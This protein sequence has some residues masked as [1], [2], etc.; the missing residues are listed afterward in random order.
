MDAWMRAGLRGANFGSRQQR[1]RPITPL[2]LALLAATPWG[3]WGHGQLGL[4]ALCPPPYSRHDPMYAC[5]LHGAPTE[6]ANCEIVRRGN[7]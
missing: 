4:A 6:P 1:G 3:G 5:V 7:L 2:Q